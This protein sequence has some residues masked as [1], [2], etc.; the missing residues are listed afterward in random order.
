MFIGDACDKDSDNDEIEDTYDNCPLIFNPAQL[1]T[2]GKIKSCD[3]SFLCSSSL[4]IILS[5]KHLVFR[6]QEKQCSIHNR[7]TVNA[8]CSRKEI[9]RSSLQARFIVVHSSGD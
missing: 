6:F 4:S 1:D 2:N 3:F 9:T 8:L 5:F 7:R